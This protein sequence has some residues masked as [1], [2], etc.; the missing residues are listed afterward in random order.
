MR[1]WLI[2]AMLTLS[3][4]PIL[5]FTKQFMDAAGNVFLSRVGKML[6]VLGDQGRRAFQKEERTR[7]Q[8]I[9]DHQAIMDAM[10]NR[11]AKAVEIAMRQHMINVRNAL[12]G[13]SG[14]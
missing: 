14:V 4:I 7:R 6:Q 3:T 2:Q 5:S 12:K 1:S 8:S 9:A 13:A 11:D 10:H